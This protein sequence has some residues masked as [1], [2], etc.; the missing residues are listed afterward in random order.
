MCRNF[1]AYFREENFKHMKSVYIIILSLIISTA[2]LSCSNNDNP[3]FGE[4]FSKVE[5]ISD[6]W[7]LIEMFHSGIDAT[8][9][10]NA[11]SNTI[12]LPDAYIGDVPATLNFTTGFDYTGT[13]NSSKVLF[14]TNG[15]WAFD[16]NDYPSKLFLTSGG[17]TLELQLLAPVREKVDPYLH[18]LYIRPF[19]DCT[20]S[21][22]VSRGT[23]GYE[24]KFARK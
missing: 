12:Q 24:Y 8:S 2:F 18:F 5:G 15:T 23:V 19:G 7:E 17:E 6:E 10:S 16:D 20:P 3:D 14:P 1:S 9:T 13:A 4:P 22:A 11:I 21:D